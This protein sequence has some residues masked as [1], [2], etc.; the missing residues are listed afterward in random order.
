MISASILCSL[1]GTK[2]KDIHTRLFDKADRVGFGNDLKKSSLFSAGLVEN[3]SGSDII[4]ENF[5]AGLHQAVWANVPTK[6]R[7]IKPPHEPFWFNL[8]A[9]KTSETQKRLYQ[10]FR[11]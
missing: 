5:S 9:R 6:I 2:S 4:W 1:S 7:R 10:C 11:K 8:E 3:H